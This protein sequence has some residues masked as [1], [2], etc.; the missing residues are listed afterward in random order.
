VVIVL[1]LPALAG[2]VVWAR[3]HGPW[4]LVIVTVGAAAL[5]VCVAEGWSTQL[6]GIPLPPTTFSEFA[7]TVAV[8]VPTVAVLRRVY[9][10]LRSQEVRRTSGVLWDVGTFWP[11]WFHPF[12]PPTYSDRAVTHLIKRIEVPLEATEDVL[13]VAA[14]SQGSILAGAAI[15]DAEPTRPVALLTFGSPWRH[16]YAEFFPTYFGTAATANLASRLRGRWRKP[17]P[18][19]RPDRRPDRRPRRAARRRRGADGRQVPSGA[20]RLLARAGVRRGDRAPSGR[21][22]G[23]AARPGSEPDVQPG[24]SMTGWAHVVAVD[25][26][27]GRHSRHHRYWGPTRLPPSAGPRQTASLA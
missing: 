14:H 3:R 17:L 8:V 9:T 1:V 15:L 16:L 11:R 22:G 26:Q 6:F 21:A 10:G 25:D 7:L 13:L 23:V 19:H 2:A 12:A 24:Q 20:F 27:A 18:Y 5:L 4:G